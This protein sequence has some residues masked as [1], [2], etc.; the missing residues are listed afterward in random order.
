M[1]RPPPPASSE[2]PRGLQPAVDGVPSYEYL[3]D[4]PNGTVVSLTLRAQTEDIPWASTRPQNWPDGAWPPPARDG[5]PFDAAGALL[6]PEQFVALA[7]S[8]GIVNTVTT[9][10]GFLR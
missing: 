3:P 1:R 8:P 4:D 10:N 2:S 9:V 6:T 7:K 5:E